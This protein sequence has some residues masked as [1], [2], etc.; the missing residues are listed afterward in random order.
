MSARER[1]SGDLLGEGVN[2]VAHAPAAIDDV[3]EKLGLGEH[4][5][6]KGPGVLV[7]RLWRLPR[8]ELA[9]EVVVEAVERMVSQ[10]PR[11]GTVQSPVRHRTRGRLVRPQVRLPHL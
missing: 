11:G 10:E 7:K 9:G 5:V 2:G 1:P 4:A 3:A 6:G 8:L